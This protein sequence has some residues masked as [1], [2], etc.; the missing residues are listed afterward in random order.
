MDK[1]DPYVY[2]TIGKQKSKSKV[3]NNGGSSPVFNNEELLLYVGVDDWQKGGKIELWDDD[4]GSDDLIAST[5]LNI[6]HMMAT[7]GN[8]RKDPSFQ[9]WNGDKECGTLSAMAYFLPFGKLTCVVHSAKGLRNPDN[10]GKPDPYVTIEVKQLTAGAIKE[11]DPEE[12]NNP[13]S[14]AVKKILK[15]VRDSQADAVAMACSTKQTQTINGSLD[16]E[17]RA[18]LSFDIVD[19]DS[20]V[21]T[22]YDE[23]TGSDD[24]IGSATVS[25]KSTR[26]A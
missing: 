1:Q 5:N 13:K 15:D 6:L 25:Q 22:C 26:Q 16:P 4:L 8:V 11:L 9:L 21:L 12:R 3:V 7:N 14:K 20:I 19:A 23:D 17:W 24:L 2:V 18:E 10:W